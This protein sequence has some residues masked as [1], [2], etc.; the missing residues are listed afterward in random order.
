MSILPTLVTVTGGLQTIEPGRSG[1]TPL[2]VIAEDDLTLYEAVAPLCAT[3]GIE[4][5]S[6]RGELA[7]VR[8]LASWSTIG[9]LASIEGKAQDGYNVMMR[10]AEYDR[11]LPVMLLTG[12][13]PA[14]IGAAEAVQ[15]LW[16]LSALTMQV[17]LPG[18]GE[19]A[20]FLCDAFR[21]GLERKH[22]R[23]SPARR[24]K[25]ER[26]LALVEAAA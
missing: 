21:L 19:L 26:R 23:R 10:V 2:L 7:L 8:Q 6:V 15:G 1:K 18:P 5:R 4:V 12:G 16:E 24:R 13:E 22:A 17:D 20:E 14:L 9:V 11:T 25:R 3:L